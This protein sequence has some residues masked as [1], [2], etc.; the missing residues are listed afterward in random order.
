MK[1]AETLL[2]QLR[3]LGLDIP[4]DAQLIRIVTS[5]SERSEGAWS[6]TVADADGIPLSLDSQGRA[7][8]I[9]SQWAISAIAGG[10]IAAHPDIFGDNHIEPDFGRTAG[11]G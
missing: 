6:W 5:R 9:G 4:D 8:A 11:G 2:T 10:K 7:M 1:A 3:E